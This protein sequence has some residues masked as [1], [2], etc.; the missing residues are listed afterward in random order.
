MVRLSEMK[1]VELL[2][3]PY[4]MPL[5]KCKMTYMAYILTQLGN[6]SLSSHRH[7]T[8]DTFLT[9]NYHLNHALIIPNTQ[10][11]IPSAEQENSSR[12][13]TEHFFIGTPAHTKI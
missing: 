9:G 13:N 12:I 2:L 4:N 7:I 1:M 11:N 8:S 6:A 3:L 10:Q 5:G